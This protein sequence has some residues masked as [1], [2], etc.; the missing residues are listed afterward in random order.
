VRRD[1]FIAKEALSAS[2][3]VARLGAAPGRET[4]TLVRRGGAGAFVP[5]RGAA[6]AAGDEVV[7]Y[8]FDR[9]SEPDFLAMNKSFSPDY[10]VADLTPAWPDELGVVAELVPAAGARVLEVCCG[11]G[12]L[13]AELCRNGNQVAALDLSAACVAHAHAHDR[14]G[15][16]FVVGDALELPFRDGAFDVS[17]IFE[18]SLGVF[19]SKKA[20]V[21][22]ELLRVARTR[23]IVG[24]REDGPDTDKVHTYY[25]N[26]GYMEAAQTFTPASAAAIVDGLAALHRARIARRVVRDGAERPWGGRTF[27]VVLE[28]SG[29]AE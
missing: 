16:S 11:A 10:Y 5:L 14:A 18:N 6:V 28:L 23:V 17:C 12:R 4:L 21:L 7:F 27:F 15:I 20:R 19:F 3:L 25:S 13:A 29:R 8:E 24:L 26:D 9:S 22:E 2:A 1:Q